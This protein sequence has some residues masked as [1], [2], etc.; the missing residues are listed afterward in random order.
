MTNSFGLLGLFKFEAFRQD[1]HGKEI[2]GTRRTIADWFPNLILD[3]GLERMGSSSTFLTYC[4]VG[5]GSVPPSPIDSGLANLLASTATV[6]ANVY[7]AQSTAPYFGWR[8]KTFR[9]AQGVASGNLSEVGVGWDTGT[10]LFSRALILDSAGA[11]TTITVG[12]D[13]TLDVTYEL[14]TQPVTAE[15]GGNIVLA[16]VSYSWVSKPAYV[17]N[18]DQW[19]VGNNGSTVQPANARAYADSMG[20]ITGGPSGTNVGV[21]VSRAP[22]AAN[23]RKSVITISASLIQ[24]NLSGGIKSILVSG[25]ATTLGSYQIEFTPAIPKDD[26]KTLSLTYDVTWGRQ[27]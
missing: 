1:E 8:R 6:T 9:F 18:Q 26:T 12:A 20:A 23:S 2:A 4:R 25:A 3:A 24:G 17:T 21:V 13:E 7:G 19:S 22:Y 14:R 27:P 15:A 10:A 16:G 5:T 11:P